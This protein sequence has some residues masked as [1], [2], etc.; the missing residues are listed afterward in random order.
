MDANCSVNRTIP[1]HQRRSWFSAEHSRSPSAVYLP[2]LASTFFAVVLS[3]LTFEDFAVAQTATPDAI[4]TQNGTL[5]AGQLNDSMRKLEAE[6]V[7]KYGEAQTPRLRTGLHQVMEFWR[8]EDG[9]AAVFES[10]VR[11]N[12]AGD[13]ESLDTMFHR[14]Q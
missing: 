14:Y 10:F 4:P 1:Q 9:D 7:A 8:P 2:I 13:R 6:L 12:F 3:T 5:T 11:T